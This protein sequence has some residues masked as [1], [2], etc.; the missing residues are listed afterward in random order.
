MQIR[1]ICKII[2][3]M[4]SIFHCLMEIR[5]LT[6]L[7]PILHGPDRGEFPP[8]LKTIM[9]GIYPLYPH[10]LYDTANRY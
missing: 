3:E 7:L 8:P 4:S 6:L 2:Y 10:P 9:A 5:K 1:N